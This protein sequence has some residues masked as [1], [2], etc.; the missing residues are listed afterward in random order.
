MVLTVGLA[1]VVIALTRLAAPAHTVARMVSVLAAVP[2]VLI[3]HGIAG[4]VGLLA[5][6][7]VVGSLALARARKHGQIGT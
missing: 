5:A 4:Q 3:A 6:A 2:L 7:V 1:V